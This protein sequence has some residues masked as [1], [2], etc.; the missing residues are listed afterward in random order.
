MLSNKPEIDILPIYLMFKEA[1]TIFGGNVCQE[2]KESLETYDIA[3]RRL[4]KTFE[5][6]NMTEN[7]LATLTE[8][9]IYSVAE[10]E[11]YADAVYDEA[12]EIKEQNK[13]LIEENK[14]LRDV[15]Y[16]LNLLNQSLKF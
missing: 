1:K 4:Y 14:N 9:A 11:F 10:L 7:P 16:R 15:N 6:K 5:D 2:V 13:R 3:L 8:S 12:N